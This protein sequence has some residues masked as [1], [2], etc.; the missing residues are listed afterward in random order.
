MIYDTTLLQ[1]NQQYRYK[2]QL[3]IY[4][5]STW[6]SRGS[7][8]FTF[9]TAKGAWKHLSRNQLDHVEA[10]EQLREGFIE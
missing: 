8:S 10:I 5:H 2:K 4:S 1:R 7:K 6:N 9:R 3:L